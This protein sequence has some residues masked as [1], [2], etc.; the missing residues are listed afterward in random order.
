MK[1]VYAMYL[2]FRI[3]KYSVVAAVLIIT[4]ICFSV[5]YSGFYPSNSQSVASIS[6]ESD[7]KGVELPIVM[8]HSML[9]D[10]KLQGQFVIDP[11]KF[12]EDLKYLKD[13]GYT[14]ITVSDLVDY[15]YNNKELPKKPIMLTFDDGYY[16]NYLYAYPLLKK[17]KCKA[18]ISPIGYYSDL[19]SKSTD[20]PSPSYSHCTWKQLKEMQNSGCVEIQNHSYNMHSQN[21]RLGIKQK[22]GESSEE[23]KEVITQDISKA[24]NRFK[25]KLKYTPQAFVYPFGA[26][27]D[28]SEEAIKA[29]S[30]RASFTCEEK[31]NIIVKDKNSLYLLGR[32]IR[33]N[34][35]TTKEL[36][37]KFQ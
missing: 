11:A 19:Y 3:S 17:Y 10:T 23:Y 24:Q 20:A 26:L 12:E 34:K 33:T 8:Y 2:N 36:F 37:N 29:L 18:V 14:T 28:S 1:W 6:S 13:N 9:K 22:N 30:F 27:S 32:F 7:T 4:T 25:E 31:I 35:M 21:G 5:M 16:N 15:V